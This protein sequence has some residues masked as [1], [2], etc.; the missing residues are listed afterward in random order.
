MTGRFLTFEGGEGSGKSTLIKAVAEALRGLGKDIV[1]TREPGGTPLAEALRT[2]LLNP[3]D[4]SEPNPWTQALIVNAAR[5]DHLS[6]LIEPALEAG[7]WVLSDRFSD[8]TRAYQGAGGTS[9]SDLIVLEEIVLGKTRP[10][11]TFIL[12]APPEALLERRRTRGG[13]SDTFERASLDFHEDVRR[14]FL[15][16]AATN[17]DRYVVLDALQTPDA[18]R[19]QVMTFVQDRLMS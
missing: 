13:K 1:V 3:E 9:L 8:S 4:G 10:D 2:L 5:H 16:I 6:R 18:L 17:T 14:R 15:A 12:D 11:L 7:K 19:D